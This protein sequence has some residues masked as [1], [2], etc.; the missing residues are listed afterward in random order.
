M[1]ELS[2]YNSVDKKTTLEPEDDVAH[3]KWGGSWR[4]PTNEEFVELSKNCTW[5]W[6]M[7]GNSEF[8]GVAGFK[9]TGKK[10]GYTDRFIFLP[11]TEFSTD[12]QFNLSLSRGMYWSSSINKSVVRDASYIDFGTSENLY[13]NFCYR[14]FYGFAVRPV[15]P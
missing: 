3:V 7:R 2:K 4:M 13:T 9:V 14:R 11:L 6:Y 5:T 12:R 8:G 1:D 10:E 15:C